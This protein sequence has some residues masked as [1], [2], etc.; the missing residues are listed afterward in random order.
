MDTFVSVIVPV[1]NAEKSLERCIN[2]ILD[3]TFRKFEIILIDDGSQ[4]N[5]LKIMKEYEAQFPERI[6]IYSQKNKG[7]A[8]TRNLGISYAQFKYIAFVDND[9]FID[10][11]YIQA[12][13]ETAE[14]NSAD[15]VLSGYRRVGP[16][17]TFLHEV[18]LFSSEW[19]KYIIMAPW[20]RVFR[21]TFL[22]ENKIEFLDNNIGE[23]VYLNLQAI[24]AT[25]DII[26]IDYCGYNW[27][28][29]E[30]SVSNSRQ[31]NNQNQLNFIHLLDSSY[32]KL[33]QL[34]ALRVPEV[35][36]F[37]IRYGIWYILFSGKLS[38]H[39]RVNDE[40]EKFFEW[41]SKKFPEFEKNRLLGILSPRDESFKN[42]L[43]VYFFMM[44]RKLKLIRYF[45][46]VYSR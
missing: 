13:V 32:S 15:I 3:N 43:I 24:N 20:A 5:S 35:E 41:L 31:K 17:D 19:S 10:R 14:N 18:I 27:F 44:L 12:H 28:Y 25:D 11:D 39:D 7:V 42:R 2:S 37:F 30:E 46:K 29:N 6:R 16:G 4:D 1:Y 22:L 40:Y 26:I 45:L 33:E 23:D 21:R 36:Y 34:N 38:E 9:D 8:V